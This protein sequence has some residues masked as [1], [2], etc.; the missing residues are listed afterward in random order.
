LI[1]SNCYFLVLLHPRLAGVL[2]DVVFFLTNR[3][4]NH[5]LL[6]D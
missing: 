6:L 5:H 3:P 1:D 4:D 2:P